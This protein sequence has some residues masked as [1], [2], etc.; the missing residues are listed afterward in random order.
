MTEDNDPVGGD[1]AARLRTLLVEAQSIHSGKKLIEGWAELLDVDLGDRSQ[2]LARLADVV[3]LP[4]QIR[5]A[6]QEA[7]PNDHEQLTEQLP[8]VEQALSLMNLDGQKWDTFLKHVPDTSLVE[9]QYISRELQR[10]RSWAHATTE[11]MANLRGKAQDLLADIRDAEGLDGDVRRFVVDHLMKVID[12]LGRFPVAGP[13]LV[14]DAVNAGAGELSMNRELR[15]KATD[16]DFWKRYTLIMGAVL[17]TMKVG[18]TSLE[19]SQQVQAAIAGPQEVTEVEMVE[20]LD[21][22]QTSSNDDIPD[23]ETDD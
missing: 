9:L 10:H 14:I 1:P 21:I 4:H 2:L 3:A 19:L 5:V 15:E 20:V 8:H 16:T 11:R 22:E 13:E 18:L 7:A 12:A 17:L 23:A 6:I